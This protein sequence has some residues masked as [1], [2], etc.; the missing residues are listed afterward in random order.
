M[1]EK[2][3][4]IEQITLKEVRD[5]NLDIICRMKTYIEYAKDDKDL[6]NKFVDKAI[7]RAKQRIYSRREV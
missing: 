1:N 2:L 5:N 4:N 3:E 6:L 7:E